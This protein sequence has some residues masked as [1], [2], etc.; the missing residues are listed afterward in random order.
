ML[1][2]INRGENFFQQIT[3]QSRRAEFSQGAG[4]ETFQRQSKSGARRRN[5]G[6]E[7]EGLIFAAAEHNRTATSS[8]RMRC[9]PGG[10]EVA[11][12]H[13]TEVAG[14]VINVSDQRPR[15]NSIRQG[16]KTQSLGSG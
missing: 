15:A 11:G 3:R 10:D 13:T 1:L 5:S 2:N 14:V 16:T 7:V 4:D 8:R 9:G 12:G 6:T